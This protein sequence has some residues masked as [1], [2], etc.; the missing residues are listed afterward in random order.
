MIALPRTRARW[1]G[2]W[3]AHD[4]EHATTSEERGDVE[5]QAIS[6]R[7]VGSITSDICV[8][9]FGVVGSE[10]LGSYAVSLLALACEVGEEHVASLGEVVRDPN[11]VVGVEINGD[12]PFAAVVELPPGSRSAGDERHCAE[13]VTVRRFELDDIGPEV[14]H[15]CGGAW[16]SDHSSGVEHSDACQR[17]LGMF[18]F[19]SRIRRRPR[20]FSGGTS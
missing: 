6:F 16:A 2:T 5:R 20:L 4:V 1:R 8:N 17:A 9:E 11:S 7:A 13:Q 10:L 19:D 14:G 15:H 3:L 18:H 12:P